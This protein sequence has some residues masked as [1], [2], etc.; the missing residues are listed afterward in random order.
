MCQWSNALVGG[1]SFPRQGS[2]D[3]QLQEWFMSRSRSS[4]TSGNIRGIASIAD[5]TSAITENQQPVLGKAGRK[6]RWNDAVGKPLD[7]FAYRCILGKRQARRE[8]FPTVFH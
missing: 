7:E 1:Q 2:A 4:D 8:G 5:H 3:S 6:K